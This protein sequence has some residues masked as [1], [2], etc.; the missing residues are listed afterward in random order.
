M[1][2][3]FLY[4]VCTILARILCERMTSRV[5]QECR[6]RGA[7]PDD[8]GL[9]GFSFFLIGLL[10]SLASWFV[11]MGLGLFLRRLLGEGVV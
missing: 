1:L 6:S 4:D 7:R 10:L 3:D 2:H 5:L 9:L 8:Y 11:F